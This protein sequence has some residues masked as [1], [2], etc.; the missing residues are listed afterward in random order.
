MIIHGLQFTAL[1][2]DL[3]MH[4]KISHWHH[5]AEYVS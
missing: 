1:I 4:V 3:L 2:F 5:K